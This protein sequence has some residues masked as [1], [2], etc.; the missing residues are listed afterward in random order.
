MDNV[1]LSG[2]VAEVASS[3]EGCTLTRV[4]QSVTG[5][6][7]LE[8][9]DAGRPLR[10]CL[11]AGPR[12]S[13]LYRLRGHP[14]LAEPLCPFAAIL[15]REALGA[16]VLG[17]QKDPEERVAS[18]RLHAASGERI[19]VA[20]LL[21]RSSN[22]I[23]LDSAGRIVAA[24]RSLRSEFRTQ[25]AGQPYA[26]PP[27]PER[28]GLFSIEEAALE[29]IGRQAGPQEGSL[30]RLLSREV[31]GLGALLARELEF[32]V[33]HRGEPL[34]GAWLDVQ[35][36][37]RAPRWE[38]HL[39]APRALEEI[40]ESTPLAPE[41]FFVAPWPLAC[42]AGLV[43]RSFD[44]LSAALE[45]HGR[46]NERWQVLER[47]R[48][49]LAH[50]F[51]AEIRRLRK[52]RAALEDDLE[53]AAQAEQFRFWGDLLLQEKDTLRIEAR[54]V[55]L[56]NRYGDGAKV[57]I[58]VDP[59]LSAQ[60][61]SE[62]MFRRYRRARRAVPQIER[63]AREVEGRLAQVEPLAEQ[64]RAAGGLAGLQAL[65]ERWKVAPRG[66]AEARTL[67]AELGERG[68]E[69]RAREYRSSDGWTILV[70][71]G[72][73]ANDR[74]TFRIAAPHDFWMHAA[75]CPGAHV[76]VRNP[77]RTPQ[78]PPRT[79]QEAA[80]L[81]AY[82]SKARGASAVDVHYTQKRYVRHPRGA[83]PGQALLKRFRTVRVRPR[84]PAQR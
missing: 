46:L 1:L 19:L 24:A 31:R 52:L 26:P 28:P 49:A 74:L 58:E 22:L 38:P 3:L 43:G 11:A 73:R 40:E 45:L 17:L 13:C 77:R 80:A 25:D 54:T 18:F 71:R 37:L 2:V 56:V 64:A 8:F 63:R 15:A 29:E 47:S 72:A 27:V 20:E 9:E 35:A 39:Y 82:F 33:R 65:A 23:W 68:P 44:S 57:R 10:L 30:A 67:R 61:N 21:G 32:R 42:A 60:Q 5:S 55:L 41:H 75:G 50:S 53:R 76:V 34:R 70:G 84:A 79:L 36:R 16:R 4:R 12:Q 83:A 51:E 48:H 6:L 69:S 66:G 78:I 14:P 62:R 81:A 7:V 59:A